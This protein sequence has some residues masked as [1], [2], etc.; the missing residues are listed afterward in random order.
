M[1]EVI[2]AMTPAL[3]NGESQ[4][5]CGWRRAPRPPARRSRVLEW[6]HAGQDG[7]HGN[8]QHGRNHQG[9]DDP[10]RQIALRVTRLERGRRGG[11]EPDIGE[12][13]M[14]APCSTPLQPK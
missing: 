11:I 14:A 6:H 3:T 9:A 5:S 12:E 4:A 7:C 10:E 13:M 8:I 2:P 1:T